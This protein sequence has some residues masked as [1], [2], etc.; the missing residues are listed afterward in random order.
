[1]LTGFYLARYAHDFAPSL[2]GASLLRLKKEVFGATMCS[3][4]DTREAVMRKASRSRT[5]RT[6]VGATRQQPSLRSV[7]EHLESRAMLAGDLP[8]TLDAI[9]NVVIDED[10]TEQTLYL[11][12]ISAGL[13]ETQPLRVTAVSNNVAVL[14]DPTIAYTSPKSFGVMTFTPVADASGVA[15]VTVTVEDGGAD[16]DLATAGDNATFS[17]AFD[18]TVL[19]VDDRPVL[20]PS[21][22]P[23][24]GSVDQDTGAPVGAVG[25]LVSSLIEAGGQL[26]NFEDADGDPLGIAVV[27]V[28][29]EGGSLWYSRDNGTTNWAPFPN[30][31]EADPLFLAADAT[32]RVYYQPAAGWSGSIADVLTFRA[33]DQV[34][35]WEQLGGDL[36]GEA[37]FDNAGKAVAMSS[38]GLTVAVGASGSDQAATNAGAVTIYRLTSSSAGDRWDVVGSPIVGEAAS[39]AAGT[40]VSLAGNGKIVA[41]AA[42]LHDG[43][44]RRDSGQVRV[45]QWVDNTGW[46]PLGGALVGEALGD[47]FGSAISL[48]AD[49]TTL[50]IGAFGNDA[51]GV[52]A[53]HAK[54]FRWN[55]GSSSWEQQG[56]TI[57]GT[58]EGVGAGTAVSLSENGSVLAVGSPRETGGTGV[59]RVYRWNAGTTSWELV[60]AEINGEASGDNFGSALSLSADG[61]VFA[62]GAI[63][64]Q[65]NGYGAGHTRV[66]RWD[67]GSSAWVQQ[68]LDLDGEAA[69]DSAGSAVALSGDASTVVIGAT[70][71]DGN[72]NNAGH[73]RVYR[74]DVGQSAWVRANSDIDGE[75]ATD[76]AGSAVAVSYNGGV[77]AVGALGH[78]GAGVQAGHV[79]V[80]VEAPAVSEATDTVSVEVVAVNKLP[81]IAAI[82]DVTVAENDG[83]QT[84]TLTGISAGLGELQPLRV[85]ATSGNP[86]TLANPVVT[87]TSPQG[88]GSLAFTPITGQTGTVT[89]DVTVEDGGLDGDL[90][91]TG[92]NGSVTVSFD[93]TVTAIADP[94]VYESYMTFTSAGYWLLNTSDGSSFT[95]TTFATWAINQSFDWT[96]VVEGDFNG[97]GLMDIAGRTNLG[98]WWASLNN[99]DGTGGDGQGGR[100]P[101]LMTYWRPG[102]D[103][104]QVVAADFNG[105]GFTDIAGFTSAGVWWVGF[106]KTGGDVGFTNQRVGGWLPQF[107]I[108]SIQTGDFDGD[109]N[110]DIAGL[111]TTGHWLGLLGQNG[112]GWTSKVLGVWSPTLN[113]SD[114]IV[115]GDFNADG[116]TDIAGRTTG[117]VWYVATANTDTIGFTTTTLG[118]WG[119]TTWGDTSV[120]DF[121]GD[122]QTDIIARAANG[123]WWGLISDGTTNLRTNRLVGY[124]NPNV[125]WTGI[126]VGDADGDGVDELIGR[127]ATTPESARGA[128]WVAD[129]TDTLMQTVRWGFQTI[130]VTKETRNLF[131]SRF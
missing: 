119:E 2:A 10:S 33:W 40:T 17:R 31:A 98:Q 69:F 64:N 109:G 108:R 52:D 101:V 41:I 30:V 24:L 89:I 6:K 12:G 11:Q 67:T 50:A 65:G 4:H 7:L 107:Q 26:D 103:I 16:G 55:S 121:N 77:V 20:D 76:S 129:I 28:N 32:T 46:T 61:L 126:T 106:A 3:C 39:D 117:N 13:G 35:L 48:S 92:D 112:G 1:M 60:G 62:A 19:A 74:W 93:V 9:A 118:I 43:G 22:S 114:D 97:D 87:Y 84:V 66:Y 45:F 81:T 70:G 85:T 120:G 83:E 116:L 56:A 96:N 80:F 130:D 125:V 59:V 128:L 82:A 47:R 14:P 102:L 111:A 115:T 49:G 23:T 104:Q 127:R 54:V 123:Q 63:G 44:G 113:F 100:A 57:Q 51:A 91:T 124:W 38:D 110:M 58:T 29:L 90:S 27:A 15:T 37:A 18:V 42:P 72:G 25:V 94:P 122:G 79:R 88:T 105:D 78:A 34:T 86:A 8:P 71:N 99:G 95:Q 131:F 73:A 21:A 53:G 36:D 68:G 75:A 5:S